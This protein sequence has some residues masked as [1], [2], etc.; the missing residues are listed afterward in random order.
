M[1]HEHV[2]FAIAKTL[3]HF[4]LLFNQEFNEFG[5]TSEQWSLLKRLKGQEGISIKDL[6]QRVEKDQGNVTRILDLLEKRGLVERRSNQNDRRSSLIYFTEEGR[7][8]VENLMPIDEKV[9]EIAIDGISEPE[10][11]M[12]M[13]VLSKI[14]QNAKKYTDS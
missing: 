5:I 13:Q 1:K 14:N 12:F 4:N 3:R 9:H 11:I 10:L 2:G 8:L 6:A 7:D